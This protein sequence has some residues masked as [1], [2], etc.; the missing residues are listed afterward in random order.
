MNETSNKK[1]ITTREGKKGQ[2]QG[3]YY[4]ED[5]LSQ[6]S[7]EHLMNPFIIA[8][9]SALGLSLLAF[10]SHWISR[11]FVRQPIFLEQR[12]IIYRRRP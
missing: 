11:V 12:K 6:A 9:I 7:K 8:T 4:L 10:L 5:P 2:L 1:G 3:V